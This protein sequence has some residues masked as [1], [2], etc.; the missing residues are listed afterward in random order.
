[1]KNKAWAVF[2]VLQD[3]KDSSM[4]P[5]SMCTIQESEKAALLA[6]LVTPSALKLISEGYKMISN[7]CHLIPPHIAPMNHENT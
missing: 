2:V 7:Q 3:P 4:L 1:M 6:L 5:V